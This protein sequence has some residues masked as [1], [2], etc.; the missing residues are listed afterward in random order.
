MKPPIILERVFKG[1]RVNKE[2]V[3]TVAFVLAG[4]GIFGL[5]VFTI[6]TSSIYEGDSKGRVCAAKYGKEFNADRHDTNPDD[7]SAPVID[8][9]VNEKTNER[10]DFPKE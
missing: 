8:V 1:F 4:I 10:K 3:S 2:A 9:C 5:F 7:Q 6:V